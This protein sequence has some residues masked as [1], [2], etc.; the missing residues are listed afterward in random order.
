MLKHLLLVLAAVPLAAVG[1]TVADAGQPSPQLANKPSIAADLPEEIERKIDEQTE[2]LPDE[3][4]EKIKEAAEKAYEKMLAAK[5]A[6]KAEEE[7]EEETGDDEEES[8]EDDDKEKDAE[9]EEGKEDKKP[10]APP[11][12]DEGKKL[13]EEMALYETK[14][15]HKV[16]EYRKELE[17][18]LLILE[19][20]KL[21]R[22]FEEDRLST[23]KQALLRERDRLKTENELEKLRRQAMTER[24]EAELARLK[25]EKLRIETKMQVETTKETLED[26]VLGEERYP[27]Q[28]FQNGELCISTRRI[29][30]NGPIMTGAADYV[31]QRLDYFNNQSSKP[32]F[33]VIDSSP[34]GSV[35]EGFHILQG[36]KESKA[37]IH[38]VVKRYA[39]SM[40]A[41]ITTLA[42]HSYC[43]P[44]AIILHHQASSS[45]RGNGRTME[46][47]KRQFD[48]ISDRLLGKV[49]KK[50]GLDYDQFVQQM[51][52]NRVSGDWDLFGDRAVEK[53]WV[54]HVAEVVREES[55]RRRPKGM[56]T[57]PFSIF[58]AQGKDELQPASNYLE[59][60]EASLHE[61]VDAQGNRFVRLP[62]LSPID[63]WLMYNPD[64]Y[65]RQ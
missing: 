63:A 46:D 59:R 30:L 57:R 22:K 51:Y 19:K 15:K 62:R 39:A 24:L 64:G 21:D 26:R 2:G 4:R 25:A 29:E 38:V 13:K 23:A 18:R 49:A 11:Q 42:D 47:Q 7:P 43:Y 52:E 37:P 65:Y 61:E 10:A 8:A 58:A 40:A 32:I 56:P 48:E 17:D 50:I 53:G 28:P 1:S 6:A 60:Y 31:C 54:E 5:E 9:K 44:N 33:I 3:I 27:D 34:G 45:L 35:I 14:F 12:T 20:A 55:I 16:F 41:C 36:M